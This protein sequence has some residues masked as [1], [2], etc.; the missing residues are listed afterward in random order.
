MSAGELVAQTSTVERTSSIDEVQVRLIQTMDD[1]HAFHE[2]ANNDR[3]RNRIGFD[4]ETSGLKDFRDKI[5]LAQIGDANTGWAMDWHRWSG[6]AVDFL[7]KWPGRIATHNGQFDQRF[8]TRDVGKSLPWDRI[9]DTMYMA[10]VHDP[11]AGKGLKPLTSKY[12]S[13]DAAAAQALLGQYMDKHGYTWETIPTD[14]PYYWGYGAMDVI[15][16]SRLV[17]IF[18]PKIAPFR[19]SYE[20]ELGAA[21]ICSEMAMRGA[22]VDHAYVERKAAQLRAYVDKCRAWAKETY[23]IKNF[24]SIPQMI[25]FFERE[26]FVF[27]KTTPKG[28]PAL[29]K[30]VLEGIDHP[31]ARTLLQVRKAQKIC[32]TYFDNFDEFSDPDDFIHADIWVCGTR[33]ARMS[34]TDPALQTLPKNDKAVRNAFIPRE[35]RR[36]VTM[37][38][39]QIELRL[40]AHYAQ[41]P[42][43]IEAFLTD[44]SFFV[45]VC[46]EALGED[47]DKEKDPRYKMVKS[48]VYARIYGAGDDKIA[49]TAGVAPAKIKE[50]NAAFDERYPGVK[51]M[52]ANTTR[53]VQERL[54]EQ[55]EAFV[56]SN[57]G[58]RLPVE[59]DKPYVGTNYMLQCT[60]AEQ[61][62]RTLIDLDS[63]GLGEYLILPVHDEVVADVPADIADEVAKLMQETALDRTRFSLPITWSADV[64]E[65]AWGG[66]ELSPRALEGG[67]EQ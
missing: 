35:G 11:T 32:S 8:W 61:L 7:G 55:G 13:R 28:A 3:G 62:K 49:H 34:V 18:E 19:E 22:R 59:P 56:Y 26:G 51:Q 52:M 43:L 58:R 10:H 29:D 39:D 41:D 63:A 38:A 67:R 15:L 9:D 37:D 42:G 2:W 53:L 16:T 21:R 17:D 40:M 54:R 50:L 46:R 1:V 45:T 36:L 30:E 12:V 6:I 31:A 14:N 66:R 5:R 23:G 64:M 24:T 60:A 57:G 47:I 33:T 25:A 20:L 65:G 44:E 4:T 48:S 27:E